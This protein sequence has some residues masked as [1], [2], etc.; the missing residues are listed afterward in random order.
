[1]GCLMAIVLGVGGFF[2]AGPVGAIIGLLVAIVGGSLGGKR[3]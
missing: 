3:A 1:M 2:V